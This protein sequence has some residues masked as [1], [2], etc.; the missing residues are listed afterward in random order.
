M[1]V[2]RYTEAMKFLRQWHESDPRFQTR[3]DDIDVYIGELVGATAASAAE[4]VPEEEPLPPPTSI[5][6]ARDAEGRLI[7]PATGQ[8]FTI[9]IDHPEGRKELQRVYFPGERDEP[10]PLPEPVYVDPEPEAPASTEV[11]VLIDGLPVVEGSLDLPTGGKIE[12][13]KLEDLGGESVQGIADNDSGTE[14][15]SDIA[16]TGNE[17][18][19]TPAKPRKKRGS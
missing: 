2:E 7:N 6:L 13:G 5:L 3:F 4:G 9:V 19:A 17:D 1:S 8:P 10:K 12:V 16:N 14:D 11:P 18:A 15:G